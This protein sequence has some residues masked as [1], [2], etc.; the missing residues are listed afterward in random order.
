MSNQQR[1][2]DILLTDMQNKRRGSQTRHQPDDR[3]AAFVI[4]YLD[5]FGYFPKPVAR[6]R[7]LELQNIRSALDNF[8]AIFG[9]VQTQDVTVH[10][11]RAME[12][13]RCGCPDIIRPHHQ[14]QRRL[15]DPSAKDLARWQKAGIAFTVVAAPAG[16]KLEGLRES[17]ILGF[18]LWTKHVKLNANYVDDPAKADVII[19]T[20]KGRQSNFDGAGGTVAWATLPDGKDKQREI[21]LDDDE[22]WVFDPRQR[23]VC[24]HHVL[25]HEIGHVLGLP[26][27]RRNDALMSPMYNPIISVPQALDDIPRIRSRYGTRETTD[28]QVMTSIAVPIDTEEVIGIVSAHGYSVTKRKTR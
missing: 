24:V 9:L 17:A 13:V 18:S 7:T 14:C 23:G 22:L 12:A 1:A 21:K 6:W 16:V 20:G 10:T 27:S 2:I 11:V 25:R 8:Q 4:A 19:G 28:T 3:V 5:K 26:H 15:L